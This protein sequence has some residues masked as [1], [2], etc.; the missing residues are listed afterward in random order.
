MTDRYPRETKEFVAVTVRRDGEPVVDPGV[1]E[2][3]LTKDRDRP[4]VWAAPT[5]VGGELRVLLEGR[6]PG[7]WHVWARVTDSP[8]VAVVELGEVIIT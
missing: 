8:E 2:V 3:A 4:T 5:V 6:G 7:L 1:V